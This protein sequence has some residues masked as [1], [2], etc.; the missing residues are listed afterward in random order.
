MT[1]GLELEVVRW[2]WQMHGGQE[3]FYEKE[4][5]GDSEEACGWNTTTLPL[6]NHRNVAPPGIGDVRYESNTFF[7]SKNPASNVEK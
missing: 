4:E 7:S 2:H 6:E 5:G 3:A 1:P